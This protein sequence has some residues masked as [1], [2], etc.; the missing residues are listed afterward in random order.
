MVEAQKQGSLNYVEGDATEPG[1]D[2]K[3][4]IAHSCNDGGAWGAGFV[5]ALDAKW[6]RPGDVYW[7]WSKNIFPAEGPGKYKNITFKLGMVMMVPVEE[8]IV[9]ANIIG[10]GDSTGPDDP[11]VKYWAIESGFRLITGWLKE[12]PGWQDATVHMPRI[13]AVLG[14]GDWGKIEAIIKKE[15]CD[16]GVD[17][18]VYDLPKNSKSAGRVRMGRGKIDPQFFGGDGSFDYDAFLNS[19]AAGKYKRNPNATHKTKLP[20]RKGGAG[21]WHYHK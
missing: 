5:K 1:G 3:K 4:V 14:G 19:E 16:N 2:G 10:Q 6:L 15:F 11:P 12:T 13:G 8:D 21:S 7:E 18:F 9:V 17:V 20:P